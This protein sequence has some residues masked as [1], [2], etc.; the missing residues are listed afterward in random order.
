[1]NRSPEGA[2]VTIGCRVP[3]AHAAAVRAYAI[4]LS[5]ETGLRVSPSA[6]GA[7]LLARALVAVGLLP[8]AEDDAPSA[9]QPRPKRTARPA[10]RASKKGTKRPRKA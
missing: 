9:P 2:R 7:A 6:A 5:K 4:K 1:M 10:A 8:S 3:V